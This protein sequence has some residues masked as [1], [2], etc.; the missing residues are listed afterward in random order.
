MS[1]NNHRTANTCKNHNYGNLR[2]TRV[3]TL[4]FLKVLFS[5]VIHTDNS[6]AKKIAC[7]P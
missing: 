7:E 3:T 6:Q 1:S 5:S 4:K 2:M